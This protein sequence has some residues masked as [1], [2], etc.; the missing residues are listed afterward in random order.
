MTE[1]KPLDDDTSP[2]APTSEE[3]GQSFLN[4][5]NVE[6]HR[7]IDVSDK[8]NKQGR[9][10]IIVVLSIMIIVEILLVFGVIVAVTNDQNAQALVTSQ[11]LC[12]LYETL[13]SSESAKARNASTNKVAYDQLVQNI[14][15][16][17]DILG[18][19]HP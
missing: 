6:T 17:I 14:Q 11:V 9:D 7:A 1:P 8:I 2:E 3:P 15:H 10:K 19:S 4:A 12:P 5:A 18:C 16:S 13:K